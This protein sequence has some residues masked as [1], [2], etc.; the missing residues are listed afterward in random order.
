MLPAE[1]PVRRRQDDEFQIAK[2]VAKDK[3]WNEALMFLWCIVDRGR[4]LSDTSIYSNDR[5]QPVASF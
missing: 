2:L 4:R 5:A 1:T 3:D